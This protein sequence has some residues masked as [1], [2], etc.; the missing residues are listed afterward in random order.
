MDPDV[1]YW[2]ALK[3]NGFEYYE[4][5]LCYVDDIL[6]ISHDPGIALVRIQAVFKFKGYKMEQLKIYLGAQVRKM[7][8]DGEEGWYISA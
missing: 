1:W 5:I 6:C 8:V 3:P 2:P 7:I 4:Y